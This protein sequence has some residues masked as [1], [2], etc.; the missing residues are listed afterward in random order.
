MSYEYVDSLNRGDGANRFRYQGF[1]ER[2]AA[3]DV[4]ITAHGPASHE[5][6]ALPKDVR[7]T[8]ALPDAG[9]RLARKA[10]WRSCLP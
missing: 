3:I 8:L 10:G 1:A 5:Q 7:L 9:A 4:D 6:R 2:V